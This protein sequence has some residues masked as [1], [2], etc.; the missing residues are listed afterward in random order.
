MKQLAFLFLYLFIFLPSSFSQVTFLKTYGDSTDKYAIS[1][2]ITTDK[3]F[4]M[5]GGANVNATD[6]EF[7]LFKT[8]SLGNLIFG[9][10]YGTG[11][12]DYFYCGIETLDGGFLLGGSTD[13][14]NNVSADIY[15]VKT[16][17]DGNLQWAK[18]YSGSNYEMARAAVQTSDSGFLIVGSTKS[19]G[20]G[21]SDCF[22]MRLDALGNIQWAK[23]YG[24]A[25]VDDGLCV[26]KTAD[27]GFAIAG[28]TLGFGSGTYDSWF[29]KTDSA[30][31]IEWDKTY[32]GANYEYTSAL[33]Q[34]QDHG[35]LQA[36]STG[37]FGVG[38][39][40][41]Y[42]VK[43]D[44]A[45]NIEWSKSYGDTTNDHLNSAYQSLDGG[46]VLSF[47]NY[48]FSTGKWDGMIIKTDAAGDTLWTRAY[49]GNYYNHCA[50]VEQTADGGYAIIATTDALNQGKSDCCLIK[51]DSLGHV[52]CFEKIFPIT[53]TSPTTLVTT[54]SPVLSVPNF[55]VGSPVTIVEAHGIE[56]VQCYTDA[57]AELLTGKF[58]LFPNPV[59]SSGN[60]FTIQQSESFEKFT[61]EIFDVFGKTTNQSG[62]L[63]SSKQEISL[64]LSPGIYFVKLYN[65]EK[66]IIQKLIV[67]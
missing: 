40:E 5:A 19:F 58:I 24:S 2:G 48:N 66:F 3:G 56:S 31:N 49:G 8:D 27:G 55:I 12:I 14:S 11:G 45:G 42:L 22:L 52:G 9:K 38:D 44:S 21:N 6:V 30:G 35:Y 53:V 36:G 37:S 34:T 43:T 17:G 1:G 29:I 32:G 62:I 10:T 59:S 28:E 16:D 15:L 57:V 54:P 26:T 47:S 61:F 41:G 63:K 65:A 20:A 18:N 4:F 60:S 33:I 23:T 64:D 25:S 46:Y 13:T 51:T 39:Y 67:Q 7:C 50:N